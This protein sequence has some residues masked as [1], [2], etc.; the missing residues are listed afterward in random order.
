M[1]INRTI[2]LTAKNDSVEE[3]NSWIRQVNSVFCC[4]AE[5]AHN[6]W[7]EHFKVAG[8]WEQWIEDVVLAFDLFVIPVR[9]LPARIGKATATIVRMLIDSHR[10]DEVVLWLPV[11]APCVE[12]NTK[13]HNFVLER[14]DPEDWKCGWQLKIE[15][16]V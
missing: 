8:S 6:Y 3:V 10:E 5:S 13:L 16:D 15:E 7:L 12:T 14:V 9:A 11:G 1:A 4:E 2:L